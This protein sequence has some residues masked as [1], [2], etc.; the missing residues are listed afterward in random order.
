MLHVRTSAPRS[1]AD[2]GTIVFVHGF[3][4]DGSMWAPQLGALPDGWRGVAPDLRGFGESPLN[5][6]LTVSTGRRLGGGIAHPDEPVLTMTRLADDI[7]DV[8][9]DESDGAAVVCGLSMGGYVTFEL[10]RRHP[11]LVRGL[12]LADT[13]ATADS[14][15]ARENRLL[16]ARTARQQGARPVA[17]GMI[18]KLLAPATREQRPGIG[19]AVRRMILGTPPATLVAALAGMACRR[20]S[21]GTL[22]G[23]RVPTL[24]IVGEEDAITPPDDARAMAA[25]IPDA[26]LEV[27]PGAGH[28][29][30]MEN[31][32]AFNR[33]LREFL[34]AL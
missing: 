19:D 1:E 16:T 24:V 21:T 11:D 7:A 4:F 2:R 13:R 8:I 10:V 28:L 20:D 33:A 25:A 22:P 5:G 29:S 31:P 26:R 9:R 23:I 32:A 12:V 6:D 3:P 18:P 14:D 17:D 15:E 34:D 30:G 27:V